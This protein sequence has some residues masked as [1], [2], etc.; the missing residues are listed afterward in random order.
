MSS[1][2]DPYHIWLG[3]PPKDQPPNHYR[4]LGLDLFEDNPDVIDAAANR[5]TAYLRGMATGEHRRESQQ[6]LNE[7]AAARRCLLD[8]EKKRTYDGKLRDAREPAPAVPSAASS[9]AATEPAFAI[10]I[11]TSDDAGR[12]VSTRTPGAA[13]VAPGAAPA[14]SPAARGRSRP[15]SGPQSARPLWQQVWFQILLGVLAVAAA[16]WFVLRDRGA[17]Q[18]QAPTQELLND[19]GSFFGASQ[20][21]TPTSPTPSSSAPPAASGPRASAA[22]AA[23][24]AD[25]AQPAA[26]GGFFGSSG[27]PLAAGQPLATGP[28]EP[29][30]VARYTF[31]D[32]QSPWLDDIRKFFGEVKEHGQPQRAE[33]P[34]RGGFLRLTGAD[35]RLEIER[36]RFKSVTIAFWIR[37]DKPGRNGEHWIKGTGL[38][39]GDITNDDK[40]DFGVALLGDR[41]AFGVGEPLTTIRSDNPVTDGRWRHVAA[42]R[43]AQTGEL[44]LYLDGVKAAAPLS[45]PRGERPGADQLGIGGNR[46][47]RNRSCLQGDLD[48]LTFIDAA[49]SDAEVAQLAAGSLTAG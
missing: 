48:D 29:P 23:A 40:P 8:A 31:S 16:L 5:Q 45:G 47:A 3:I 25:A 38:V 14:K 18:Q 10:Q 9:I 46:L 30:V 19:D 27:K 42:V 20:D 13:V 6:L 22:A 35:C 49:L 28:R 41:I 4:L 24:G 43:D 39:D 32:P 21:R 12:A 2:F 1:T 7:I 34:G 36:P 44:R 15:A 37:T 11:D 17:G 33:E 26:T